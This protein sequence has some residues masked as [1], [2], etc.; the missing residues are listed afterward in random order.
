MKKLVLINALI[1]AMASYGLAQDSTDNTAPEAQS[2]AEYSDSNYSGEDD[3]VVLSLA[4]LATTPKEEIDNEDYNY[5][6]A[7]FIEAN[8]SDIFG[9]ETGVMYIKKQ[10]VANVAGA[11][12][13]DEVDRLHIPAMAR[14]WATDFLSVAAGPYIA[15]SVGDVERTVTV[16][17]AAVNYESSASD[18]IELGLDV[19]G[20]LNLAIDDKSGIFI[21]GRYSQPVDEESAEDVDK[22]T[23]LAGF[24]IDI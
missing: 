18:D 9:F 3:S 8:K 10:Y 11:K 5:G 6:A 23:A 19:A 7:I 20:T 14:L 24:K 16:G 15:F 13:V 21:E 12:V 22:A 1:A 17:D 4:G 2:T